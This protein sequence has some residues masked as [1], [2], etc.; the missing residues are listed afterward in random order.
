MAVNVLLAALSA[1]GH[2]HR[3]L[4]EVADPYSRGRNRNMLVLQEQSPTGRCGHS[5]P[6]DNTLL[7]S[8][9]LEL[10]LFLLRQK[11]RLF[12]P[13]KGSVSSIGLLRAPVSHT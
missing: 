10:G 3:A 13:G 6:L 2:G 5:Y 9:I 11:G 12:S 7:F 1:I 4:F 8:K